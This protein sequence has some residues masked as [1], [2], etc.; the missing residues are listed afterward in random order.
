MARNTFLRPSIAHTFMFST[1]ENETS[2]SICNICNRLGQPAP[3]YPRCRWS[4]EP[5]DE[6]EDS[7]N[8]HDNWRIWKYIS[9]KSLPM[10][11]SFATRR[12]LQFSVE[13]STGNSYGEKSTATTQPFHKTDMSWNGLLS[14][15]R[16][17]LASIFS[18]EVKVN[19]PRLMSPY[20]AA[21]GTPAAETREVNATP[22]GRIVQV[23]IAATPHTTRTA[24]LG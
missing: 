10:A 24:F 13:A 22:D 5:R 4:E 2:N 7:H 3:R 19:L 17:H 6:R 16:D 12:H 9:T 18:P 8:S 1:C 20:A 15:P 11:A 21:E 14:R 23:I